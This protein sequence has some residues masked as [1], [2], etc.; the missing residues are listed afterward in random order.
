MTLR[1][2]ILFTLSLS[3][4]GCLSSLQTRADGAY[5]SRESKAMQLLRKENADLRAKLLDYEEKSRLSSGKIEE[6]QI[7]QSRMEQQSAQAAAQESEELKAYKESVSELL[8]DKRKLEKEILLLKDANRQAVKDA[9]DAKKT[10]LEHL[11]VADKLFENKKWSDAVTE[12]QSFRE[13]AKKKSSNQYALVTYKMGVCF[14]ELGM[15]KEAK[16]FYKSVV[17]KHKNKKAGR[18]AEYRL[19]QIA[20][21]SKKK[22]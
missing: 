11:A 20:E 18:Y 9:K 7:I 1:I 15:E 4:G 13:K 16:T 17:K 8:A 19:N 2:F 14:Q 5:S 3:L 6:L 21:K 12:Y 22:K 10:A